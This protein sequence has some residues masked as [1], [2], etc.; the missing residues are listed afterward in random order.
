MEAFGKRNYSPD[1]PSRT[2]RRRLLND[3]IATV[4]CKKDLVISLL[5]TVLL[6]LLFSRFPEDM[7]PVYDGNS[8]KYPGNSGTVLLGYG[9]EIAEV[10]IPESQESTEGATEEDNE[11]TVASEEVHIEI[12]KE[13][14]K[15]M[16]EIVLAF[17]HGVAAVLIGEASALLVAVAWMK[18]RRAEK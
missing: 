12:T 13:E 14:Q 18:I 3:L 9:T 15:S 6:I 5:A 1:A 17:W 7:P 2:A 4:S 16:N 10:V 11:P 8:P